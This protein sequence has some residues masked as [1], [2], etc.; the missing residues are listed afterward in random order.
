MNTGDL[1]QL[2]G[3]HAVSAALERAPRQVRTLL[4]AEESRNPR[5]D[6]L[7]EKARALGLQVRRHP[8]SELDR[9]SGG[10]RHQDLIA[11]FSPA[12]I[13]GEREL[14]A[15]LEAAR[16]P[17][18]VLV[19]DGVQDPQ[20]L[21]ACLRTADAA[22]VDFVVMPKDRSAPL[23][24]AARRAASGAAEILPLLLATNLARVLRQLKAAGLWLAGT[25]ED[26]E[27]SI[28]DVDLSGPL[29]LVMGSEGRGMRR[30][31]EE[32]CDYRV[33]IPMRGT[34][35]SLNV[36]AAAAVCLFEVMRQNAVKYP[37]S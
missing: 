4:V 24:P 28:F 1:S 12:N 19:L 31:T 23:S 10:A 8:R 27:Q 25:T 35:A 30:L 6:P 29:A 21:G 26:A 17:P 36:S 14:P 5:L 7:I 20:N 37:N 13:H 34:V 9:I 32:L 18:L 33:S 3:F 16:Q 11:E 2:M 22:G 15:L